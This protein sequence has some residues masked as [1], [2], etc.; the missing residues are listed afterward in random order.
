[1][2]ARQ[3]SFLP[4]HL[5]G[6]PPEETGTIWE[7]PPSPSSVSFGDL[8]T[9]E[10]AMNETLKFKRIPIIKPSQRELAWTA[11]E[12][13]FASYLFW[14]GHSFLAGLLAGLC[15]GCFLSRL[16]ALHHVSAALDEKRLETSAL[17]Q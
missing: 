14:L 6:S 10:S 7:F 5:T 11:F 12:L 15:I 1:M 8:M 17:E 16:S 13:I 3:P 4:H 2:F 9:K